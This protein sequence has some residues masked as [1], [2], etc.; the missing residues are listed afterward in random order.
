ME[1]NSE[2]KEERKEKKKEVKKK[3]VSTKINYLELKYSINRDTFHIG[4]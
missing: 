2:N 1:S 4:C 3:D